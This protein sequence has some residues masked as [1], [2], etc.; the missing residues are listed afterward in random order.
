MD[1]QY[2]EYKDI[3]KMLGWVK[4]HPNAHRKIV[5]NKDILIDMAKAYIIGH[6][7]RKPFIELPYL[8]PDFVIP[9]IKDYVCALTD[10]NSPR[11]VVF[12]ERIAVYLDDID[13]MNY[14][15]EVV[16]EIRSRFIVKKTEKAEMAI[17]VEAPEEW[18]GR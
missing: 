11:K 8:W 10:D 6:A 7:K 18:G 5:P 12:D 13:W 1:Y 4:D 17:D 16:K 9:S 15:D 14:D 3:N 2:C